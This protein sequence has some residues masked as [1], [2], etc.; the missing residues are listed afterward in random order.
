M[1][2]EEKDKEEQERDPFGEKIFFSVG[3]DSE[4]CLSVYTPEQKRDE[5]PSVGFS[6]RFVKLL[7]LA[8]EFEFWPDEIV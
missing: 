7:L 3:R 8:G 6:P 4:G 1:N 2:K 5:E